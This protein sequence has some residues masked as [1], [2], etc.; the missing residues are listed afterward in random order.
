MDKAHP[1]LI[2]GIGGTT[3]PGSSTERALVMA[4]A[5]VLNVIFW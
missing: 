4:L 5:I 2:V 1:R 3:L